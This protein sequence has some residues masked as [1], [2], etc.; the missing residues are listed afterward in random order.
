[1][2]KRPGAGRVE[3]DRPHQHHMQ[4]T[5][6]HIGVPLFGGLLIQEEIEKLL[7]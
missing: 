2:Y 5:K 6:R 3:E 4:H 1:M 7:T